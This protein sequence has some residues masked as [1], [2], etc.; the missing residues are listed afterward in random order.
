MDMA[1]IGHAAICPWCKAPFPSNEPRPSCNECEQC[2]CS[3]DC[4]GQFH[5]GNTLAHN[6]AAPIAE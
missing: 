4:R 1:C 3:D 6:F 2:F 5:I